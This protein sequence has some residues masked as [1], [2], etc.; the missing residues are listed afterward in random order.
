[1]GVW[2]F[3]LGWLRLAWAGLSWARWLAGRAD[4]IRHRAGAQVGGFVCCGRTDGG[5]GDSIEERR[6]CCEMMARA[7]SVGQSAMRRLR[8]AAGKN[9]CAGGARLRS[10]LIR[11]KK[12]KNCFLGK[13]RRLLMEGSVATVCR[14]QSDSDCDSDTRPAEREVV[15]FLVLAFSRSIA[16]LPATSFG[17]RGRAVRLVHMT[18]QMAKRDNAQ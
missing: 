1:M 6:T 8:E 11:S 9:S 15:L 12:K 14:Y 2:S 4:L 13:M 16:C 5:Q 18:A 10:E 3:A 7:R 17:W